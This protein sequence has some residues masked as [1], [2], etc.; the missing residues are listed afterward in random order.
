[1]TSSWERLLD[2]FGLRLQSDSSENVIPDNSVFWMTYLDFENGRPT[3]INDTFYANVWPD[4][5]PHVNKRSVTIFS[6]KM[7]LA[8]LRDRRFKT[9]TLDFW[10]T[11]SSEV[12]AE[13]LHWEP[14]FFRCFPWRWTTLSH[15][16]LEKVVKR[17][18][19]DDEHRPAVLT[20]FKQFKPRETASEEIQQIEQTFNEIIKFKRQQFTKELVERV[21]AID[22]SQLNSY[23]K[24]IIREIKLRIKAIR[25][26]E[27]PVLKA[28]SVANKM[29][30]ELEDTDSA[31]SEDYNLRFRLGCDD[32]K[33]NQ[34]LS[35]MKYKGFIGELIFAEH[36]GD[37]FDS[38][39]ESERMVDGLPI[40]QKEAKFEYLQEHLKPSIFDI[41]TKTS[42]EHYIDVNFPVVIPMHF[43]DFHVVEESEVG[44]VFITLFECTWSRLNSKKTINDSLKWEKFVKE[45]NQ[46]NIKTEKIGTAYKDS[47]IVLNVRPINVNNFVLK[48]KAN[49]ELAIR[50]DTV[51]KLIENYTQSALSNDNPNILRTIDACSSLRFPKEVSRHYNMPK[52][53]LVDLTNKVNADVEKDTGFKNYVEMLEKNVSEEEMEKFE[54]ELMDMFEEKLQKG[55]VYNQNK[56][57]ITTSDHLHSGVNHISEAMFNKERIIRLVSNNHHDESQFTM[58]N[59]HEDVTPYVTEFFSSISD[60]LSAMNE[61]QIAKLKPTLCILVHASAGHNTYLTNN[62]QFGFCAG[63]ERKSSKVSK[64]M[65]FLK[66]KFANDSRVEALEKFVSKGITKQPV[67]VTGDK[68]LSGYRTHVDPLL[69]KLVTKKE[70]NDYVYRYT[71]AN[72]CTLITSDNF[73]LIEKPCCSHMVLRFEHNFN[74]V[75]LACPKCKLRFRCPNPFSQLSTHIDT[76]SEVS[77]RTSWSKAGTVKLLMALLKDKTQNLN[78]FLIGHILHFLIGLTDKAKTIISLCTTH[79]HKCHDCHKQ[80]IRSTISKKTLK[81][82]EKKLIINSGIISMFRDISSNNLK[83][84]STTIIEKWYTE[85]LKYVRDP[86]SRNL[87]KQEFYKLCEDN[88]FVVCLADLAEKMILARSQHFTLFNAVGYVNFSPSFGAIFSSGADP[89]SESIKSFGEDEGHFFVNHRTLRMVQ[90]LPLMLISNKLLVD[91]MTNRKCVPGDYSRDD[92]IQFCFLNSRR[93]NVNLQN[94]RYFF[95]ACW[96][97]VHS[98]FLFNKLEMDFVKTSELKQCQ[99]IV[100]FMKE[101]MKN[102]DN[103]DEKARDTKLPEELADDFPV[104]FNE[105]IRATLKDVDLCLHSFYMVHLFEK[106]IAGRVQEIRKV[107]EKFLKPKQQWMDHRSKFLR[108]ELEGEDLSRYLRADGL[109][110]DLQKCFELT[111]QDML[112]HTNKFAGFNTTF[113][114][115]A[116]RRFDGYSKNEFSVE[117][118]RPKSVS[119]LLKATSTLKKF[120]PSA[121]FNKVCRA[122]ETKKK[123]SIAMKKMDDDL[124]A[125]LAELDKTNTVSHIFINCCKVLNEIKRKDATDISDDEM[126]KLKSILMTLDFNNL[127]ETAIAELDSELSK[128]QFVQICENFCEQRHKLRNKKEEL[129]NLFTSFKEKFPNAYSLHEVNPVL[130]FLLFSDQM[131]WDLGTINRAIEEVS[132]SKGDVTSTDMSYALMLTAVKGINKDSSYCVNSLFSSLDKD[133]TP[134]NKGLKKRVQQCTAFLAN[135]RSMTTALISDILSLMNDDTFSDTYTV[136]AHFKFNSDPILFAMAFKE[137]FGGERELTIGDI[138]SKLTLKIVEDIAKNLGRCMKNTCLNEPDNEGIFKDMVAKTQKNNKFVIDNTEKGESTPYLYWSKDRSKWGPFH[139]GLAFYTVIRILLLESNSD[140]GD[141]IDLVKYSCLKHGLKHFEI[142]HNIIISVFNKAMRKGILYEENG[143]W[144]FDQS[145]DIRPDIELANWEIF[146]IKELQSGKKSIHTRMDM[147]QGMLHSCS[148]VYGAVIDNYIEKLTQR[149]FKKCRNKNFTTKTM[150][151][152]DDSAAVNQFSGENSVK[153]KERLILEEALINDTCQRMGNMIISEKSVASEHILEFKSSFMC[154]GEQIRVLI[155]FLSTQLTIGKDC[156]PEDFFNSYNSLVKSLLLNGGS[157][158]MCDLIYLAKLHQ[159]QTVY[160]FSKS[161]F[162]DCVR[163]APPSRFGMP[164]L[165]CADIYYHTTRHMMANRT[166]NF[167][168]LC[169]FSDDVFTIRK[170][171]NDKTDSKHTIT[172]KF[173]ITDK[174]L[175]PFDFE[176]HNGTSFKTTPSGEIYETKITLKGAR[177]PI[178]LYHKQAFTAQKLQV[179]LIRFYTLARTPGSKATEAICCG[180]NTLIPSQRGKFKDLEEVEHQSLRNMSYL[181][182]YIMRNEPKTLKS[183]KMRSSQALF[184]SISE[185]AKRAH[186]NMVY[187]KAALL[188]K[189]TFCFF[190]NK[191]VDQKTAQNSFNCD[192]DEYK[193]ISNLIKSMNHQYEPLK[194]LIN[195][196]LK[197]ENECVIELRDSTTTHVKMEIPLH[198]NQLGRLHYDPLVVRAYIRNQNFVSR[199]DALSPEDAYI[200]QHAPYDVDKMESDATTYKKLFSKFTDTELMLLTLGYEK[201]VLEGVYMFEQSS[202]MKEQ[203]GFILQGCLHNHVQRVVKL[204]GASLVERPIDV[205]SIQKLLLMISIYTHET[206]D[207]LAL[208]NRIVG[209]MVKNFK[210]SAALLEG[211][212]D[213]KYSYICSVIR[214]FYQPNDEQAHKILLKRFKDLKNFEEIGNIHTRVWIGTCH[215]ARFKCVKELD[216]QMSIELSVSECSQETQSKIVKKLRGIFELHNEVFNV[217][218]DKTMPQPNMQSDNEKQSII[219]EFRNGKFILCLAGESKVA[220]TSFLNICNNDEERIFKWKNCVEFTCTTPVFTETSLLWDLVHDDDN[221]KE[222]IQRTDFTSFTLTDYKEQFNRL[223]QIVEVATVT[224]SQLRACLMSEPFREPV[225]KDTV[226]ANMGKFCN[227][228]PSGIITTTNP[229]AMSLLQ[230]K[231]VANSIRQDE[232]MSIENFL[233]VIPSHMTTV[234]EI[235]TIKFKGFPL[236]AVGK[237][238]PDEFKGVKLLGHNYYSD[239]K[240]L[241]ENIRQSVEENEVFEDRYYL[242]FNRDVSISSLFN[243]QEKDSRARISMIDISTGTV[244]FNDLSNSNRASLYDSM[245]NEDPCLRLCY[246]TPTFSKFNRRKVINLDM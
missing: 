88:P 16:K 46:M 238:K 67:W 24:Y 63:L 13:C 68:S 37:I 173:R 80:Q 131:K 58:L 47:F 227:L 69:M 212:E 156:F 111:F 130:S 240:I 110:N 79:L 232:V 214:L 85:N 127:T 42:E 59:E 126:I 185:D 31:R 197:T 26:E 86:I 113:I 48:R 235:P 22:E 109:E 102:F 6:N 128:T 28:L 148:D 183:A 101:V 218:V 30:K 89:N 220:N 135:S 151:T 158:M 137:Q 195:G 90:G 125:Y 206:H 1:M 19:P 75:Q 160:T 155:K 141:V 104:L 222:L 54:N 144:I 225:V 163:D 55:F 132:N 182:Y 199:G 91:K 33:S 38:I 184:Q 239:E 193:D 187:A 108:D 73:S 78:V 154:S 134:R 115:C 39:P 10:L 83:A 243:F 216:N 166:M 52:E 107:F 45:F 180:V 157:Q 122:I 84:Q 70:D 66:G 92:L 123:L 145:R 18:Q 118:R 17:Y 119:E 164:N 205:Q 230:A 32:D 96:S 100:S 202:D 181:D 56:W 34:W 231:L 103:F 133:R 8:I 121:N 139:Q 87:L 76:Y 9:G 246:I 170:T 237:L 178:L 200:I 152:S 51:E 149:F 53:V 153:H 15:E 93:M 2:P 168:R 74:E 217:T 234:S 27:I 95:M 106:T 82:E 162:E 150:N 12:L 147:G 204:P 44:V 61:I 241:S 226:T 189:G 161:V 7:T 11:Q 25:T 140:S 192:D 213:K 159:M 72:N 146:V 40:F 175:L 171:V 143:A 233:D 136:C 62:N 49:N 77:E 71:D 196:P 50:I 191:L 176:S 210:L 208:R 209:L 29:I 190:G 60:F 245:I 138:W 244:K 194:R 3:S 172:K 114:K 228:C 229:F 211:M 36:F 65:K 201:N 81:P 221:L 94:I 21:R 236:V 120:E 215:G 207:E 223:E 112:N 169:G 177:N 186:Q 129:Q 20:W 224:N 14:E 167:V 179:D 142:H 116:A 242:V 203:I 23:E 174:A 35:I 165:T 219:I 198:S 57:V 188:N 105:S 98:P 64:L 43:P 97:K 5:W 124:I 4:F 99:K 41:I 117:V